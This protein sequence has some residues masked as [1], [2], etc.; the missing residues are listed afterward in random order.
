[1]S[2]QAKAFSSVAFTRLQIKPLASWISIER[3]TPITVIALALI[4]LLLLQVIGGRKNV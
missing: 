2:Q 1:M 3:N 4:A